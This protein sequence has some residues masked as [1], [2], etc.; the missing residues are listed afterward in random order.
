MV[1]LEE[2][3]E[4]IWITDGPEIVAAAGFHYPTRA[5]VIRLA[6]QSLFVW[7]P[8]ELDQALRDA[9]NELGEVKY[10][11]APNN[12]HH[13]FLAEWRHA[14]PLAKLYAAPGLVSKREDLKFD[15]ILG[16]TPNME[17]VDQIDQVVADGNVLT[18]EVVF[19]HRKS[20]TVLFTDLLQQMPKDWYRGWR[21][22]VAMLD[23]MTEDQPTVP[24]KFRLAFK[25]RK[26]ARQAIDKI[27]SWPSE[28]VLMAHGT[29]V[30]SN[31]QQFIKDAFNWLK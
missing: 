27:E 13:S 5:A 14:Y 17:W 25:D 22:I 21:R 12:L 26:A 7:S 24:R 16:D 18:N 31:G 28:K 6:D 19:Y 10:L 1:T 9:V 15:G 8:I 20:R 23:L 4:D 3:A 29:P 30:H 2:F 11:I